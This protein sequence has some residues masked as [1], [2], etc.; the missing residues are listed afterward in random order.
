MES[1]RHAGYVGIYGLEDYFVFLEQAWVGVVEMFVD[2]SCHVVVCN[3]KIRKV[4]QL[5]YQMHEISLV[6]ACYIVV[7]GCVCPDILCVAVY[8][9]VANDG[10]WRYGSAKHEAV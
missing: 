6:H 9:I 2:Y 7:V 1:C 4:K 10:L 5:R 8:G 3:N